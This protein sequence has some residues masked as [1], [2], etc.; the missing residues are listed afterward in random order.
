[1]TVGARMAVV[2]ETPARAESRVELRTA[3]AA[4]E[5]GTEL[6]CISFFG[7]FVSCQRFLLFDPAG[8]PHERSA[9]HRASEVRSSVKRLEI[10]GLCGACG[11]EAGNQ[12]ANYQ[13]RFAQLHLSS[14]LVYVTTAISELAEEKFLGHSGDDALSRTNRERGEY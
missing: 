8:A 6:N 10:V 3:V 13:T 5:W 14:S 4:S 9:A 11:S 1:V 7:G 2:G 12:R